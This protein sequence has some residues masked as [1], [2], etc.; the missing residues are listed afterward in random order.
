MP[1][2]DGSN[3]GACSIRYGSD[4]AARD[5]A[6]RLRKQLR[7]IS[8]NERLKISFELKTRRKTPANITEDFILVFLDVYPGEVDV[9]YEDIRSKFDY[10]IDDGI[11][12][13]YIK[14]KDLIE[15][16]VI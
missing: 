13:A 7:E 4:T 5:E 12:T 2:C 8:D 14:R 10:S 15:M 9:D 6:E 11:L 16:E 3:C 1:S